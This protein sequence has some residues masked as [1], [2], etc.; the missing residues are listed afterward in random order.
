M[1]NIGSENLALIIKTIRDLSNPALDNL[2][3][4]AASNTGEYAEIIASACAS[5]KAM[6]SLKAKPTFS[7]TPRPTHSPW[8]VVQHAEELAPGIWQVS[9]PSH[10]GLQVSTDR[11]AAMP[12]RFRYTTYSDGAWFEEDCDW[13]LVAVAFPDV[14]NETLYRDALNTLRRGYMS[15]AYK[16]WLACAVEKDPTKR[17]DAEEAAVS[18]EIQDALGKELA[19]A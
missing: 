6:R 7:S 10:G 16:T 3:A 15:E 11:L 18:A 14:F 1:N 5:E 17:T 12:A 13:A 9:T 19:N 2:H 4:H 8:G